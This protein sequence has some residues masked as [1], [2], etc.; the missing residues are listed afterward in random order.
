[1]Q[2]IIITGAIIL[3]LTFILIEARVLE[4]F[5]LFLIV[6]IVPSTNF[7]VS[8]FIMLVG[9]GLAGWLLLVAGSH[10]LLK[11]KYSVDSPL[12]RMKTTPRAYLQR[13]S[14]RSKSTS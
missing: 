10:I 3:V 5:L 8:P 11:A 13:R 7:T 4:A 2:R 14:Q 9:T 1:M 6:G 12:A